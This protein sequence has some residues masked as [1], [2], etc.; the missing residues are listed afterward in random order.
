VTPVTT[1]LE[2]HIEEERGE[3][4]ERAHRIRFYGC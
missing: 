4:D 1:L 3:D 2:A